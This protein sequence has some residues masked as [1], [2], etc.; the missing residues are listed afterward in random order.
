MAGDYGEKP[1][2]FINLR[3]GNLENICPATTKSC[4]KE[5]FYK[6]LPQTW[7]KY[8]THEKTQILLFQEFLDGFTQWILSKNEK[9]ERLL[10][11][12]MIEV[13]ANP[14]CLASCQQKVNALNV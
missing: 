1:Q 9:G 5:E 7:S 13:M 11:L 6:A 3:N 4:C 8:G 14:K 12:K 10:K 2:D